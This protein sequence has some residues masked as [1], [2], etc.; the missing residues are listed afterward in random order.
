MV[1][2]P[3]IP[4]QI[5][6]DRCQLEPVAPGLDSKPWLAWSLQEVQPADGELGTGIQIAAFCEV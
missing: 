2:E 5:I 3:M 4:T 6:N 1:Y